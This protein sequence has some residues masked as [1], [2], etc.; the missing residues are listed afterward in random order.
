MVKERTTVI[1]ELDPPRD[2]DYATFFKGA[3]ALHKVGADAITLADNSLAMTR[4]SNMAIGTILENRYGIRPLLHI[5]CRDR[6]LI[7]L[8]SHLMGLKVLD[9]HD[10]LVVTGDAP[11]HGD[12]PHSSAVY[13]VTSFELIRKIKKMNEG[14][15]FSGR[16]LKQNTSFSVGAAFNPNTRHLNHAIDRLQK[17]IDAG[18]DFAMSQPIYCHQQITKIAK[19]T[20]HLPIPIFLG[21]MPFVSYKNAEFLHTK[22]PGITVPDTLIERMKQLEG[23]GARKEGI[24]I[25]KELIDTALE[26]FR[27]IYLITPFLQYETTVEL[28]EYIKRK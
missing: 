2:L 12:L 6:N 1:V 13:D 8:Q 17:K 22:V 5:T 20:E 26:L 14:L 11:R 25:A 9:I 24:K 3:E 27:G 28:T 7:G 15:S 10:I 23:E 21:I 19:E 16:P 18:C 4:I